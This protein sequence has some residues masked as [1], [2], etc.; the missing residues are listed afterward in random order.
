LEGRVGRVVLWLGRRC[1]RGRGH[2]GH[3]GAAALR[4]Q[5]LRELAVAP[6]GLLRP[7]G[8]NVYGLSWLRRPAGAIT[9]PFLRDDLTHT[10]GHL[11]GPTRERQVR[12]DVISAL[13]APRC[14]TARRSIMM[15]GLRGL[16]PGSAAPLSS[17]SRASRSSRSVTA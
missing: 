11:A 16:G 9:Y 2:P 10:V 14:R 3:H 13:A 8:E 15:A 1:G 17:A 4:A 12:N 5:D 6:R 7:H